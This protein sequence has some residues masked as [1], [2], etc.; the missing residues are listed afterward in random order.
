MPWLAIPPGD[1]R[2]GKLGQLYGVR[3]IPTLV[4]VDGATGVTINENARAAVNNDPEGES[5]PWRATQVIQAAPLRRQMS[6][7]MSG[8]AMQMAQGGES[9]MP[10]PA[11][12]T[13]A[14]HPRTL[15]AAQPRPLTR[16]RRASSSCYSTLAGR[17]SCQSSSWP[18]TTETTGA[19][20]YTCPP[21][22]RPPPSSSTTLLIHH[23]TA[24]RTQYCNKTDLTLWALVFGWAGMG[25][26]IWQFLGQVWF[27]QINWTYFT[28]GG[29][30]AQR[31]TLKRLNLISYIFQAAGVFQFGPPNQLAFNP[32]PHRLAA[33]PP[34]I[35]PAADASGPRLRAQSGS[36]GASP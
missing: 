4:L 29:L 25:I 28:T 32:K 1:K 14:T 11:L 33:P 10:Y 9:P 12:R 3:G 6:R 26:V 15:V 13:L 21:S 5:F 35:E 20:R 7:Q 27:W 18:T 22:P 34:C 23:T 19:T 36:A 8:R 2:N 17:A 30:E 16:G 31:K 24:L